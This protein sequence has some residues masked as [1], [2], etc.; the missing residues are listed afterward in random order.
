MDTDHPLRPIVTQW[1]NKIR[2]AWEWKKKKFQDDADEAMQF[3]NGPYDWLY[4]LKNALGSRGFVYAGDEGELPRPSFAMTVNKVAELV[5]LFGPALY[6][7][8]PIRQVN[9]RKAVDVPFDLMGD[10]Q[11]PFVQMAVQQ[12]AQQQQLRA[13]Q[14][15]ARAV[16]LEAYQNYTPTALDLKTESRWAIDEGIIKGRGVLWTELYKPAGGGS[17]LVGSFFDTV[18]NLVIDPDVEVVRDAWWLARRCVKPYWEVEEEFGLPRDSLKVRAT[19]E[20]PGRQADIAADP[21]GDYNRRRGMTNDLVVYWKVF[22]RM[23]VGGRLSGVPE[24]IRQQVESW[25]RYCYLVVSEFCPYPLNIPDHLSKPALGDDPMLAMHSTQP[26]IE[27]LRW[28]TPYWADDTFPC[29]FLD[30]H[31]VP[32]EVW[33]MSHLR[34]GIGELKFLNWAYSFLAGKVK[35]ATRDFIAI[36]KSASDELKENIR[37]GQDYT[38]LEVE[39]I[40]DSIDKVVKFLQHPEFN[41]E[42]YKVIQGVQEMFEKRVGLTELM[43]G[44][45]NRQLRSAEEANIKGDQVSIR[46][47]DMANRVEDWMSDVARKEALAARW[48]LSGKDVAPVLGPAGAFWWDKLVAPADPSEILH[49]LEYRIEAGSARKPNKARDAQNM[50]Q[51]MQALFAPL[52]QYA[53]ATGNVGPVNA[54]ITAWAKSIDLEAAPFLM[55]PPPPQQQPGPTPDQIEQQH[56]QEMAHKEQSQQQDLQHK[57][58][59]HA[60][61]LAQQQQEGRMDLQQHLADLGEQRAQLQ[62]AGQEHIAEMIRGGQQHFAQLRQAAEKHAVDTQI[63][64]E[65]AKQAPKGNGKQAA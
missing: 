19:L 62:M 17:Q 45:S 53:G 44:M 25:G 57:A 27:Q 23:G 6:H 64:K 1:M 49:Q 3:F 29:S 20:S 50:Q 54:L 31:P 8:N 4:G 40:H 56:Q 47:D 43:Y 30:F 22:S 59:K 9:P 32:R 2:L 13:R 5:Q 61:D 15:Q 36:A 58:Q 46:P 65:K 28:P 14:D 21:N 52:M 35:T 24:Q 60:L 48:H 41:P 26:I 16:L 38:F 34:P 42:I 39:A 63:A 10:P 11:N 37:T 7:R 55:Q 51:A 33:P 18:D 12:F